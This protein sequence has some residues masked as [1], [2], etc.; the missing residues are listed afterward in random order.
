MGRGEA[1]RLGLL[2]GP[3]A[4]AMLRPRPLESPNANV[5]TDLAGLPRAFR[6]RLADQMQGLAE[7]DGDTLRM[8]DPNGTRPYTAAA[9]AEVW[10]R[11]LPE[12]FHDLPG[13]GQMQ[14]EALR[15]WAEDHTRF[16]ADTDHPRT[17]AGR[18]DAFE[19][20][21]RAFMRVEP[22]PAGS[23]VWRGLSWNRFEGD[24]PWKGFRSF[25]DE[26]EESG[27][28][29]PDPAKPADSWSVAESGARKYASARRFQVTMVC[30]KA[31]TARD[32]GPLVRMLRK[33][34]ASP[35]PAHPVETDGEAVFLNG[36][37]F[38]VVRI[39]INEQTRN[40]G[41]ATVYVEEE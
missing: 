20:V 39:E 10:A 14:R 28:Y 19:D 26:L 35:D 33:G 5:E 37:R 9:L 30:R 8:T 12:R 17:S 25:L 15:L 3:E 36:T 41:R 27:Y 18:L 38:R 7:W 6:E 4:A 16:Q 13:E 29:T 40:G 21:T 11:P 2:D 23:T 1:K 32:I 31:R 34:I 22:M 24:K